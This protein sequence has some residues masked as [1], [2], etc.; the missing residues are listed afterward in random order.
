M[1]NVQWASSEAGAIAELAPGVS[2]GLEDQKAGVASSLAALAFCCLFGMR[3]R[4]LIPTFY[5]EVRNAP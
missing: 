5:L 3:M 2:Q 1:T 4:H